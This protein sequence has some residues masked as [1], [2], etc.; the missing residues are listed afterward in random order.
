[1]TILITFY[2]A[3][4][5]L[6]WYI[7]YLNIINMPITS[8]QIGISKLFLSNRLTKTYLWKYLI[9]CNI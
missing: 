4:Y 8:T 2:A 3:V 5:F 1:M 9:F 6:N 7:N